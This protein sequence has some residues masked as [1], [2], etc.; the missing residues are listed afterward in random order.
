MF[1]VQD[2]LRMVRVIAADH[3][4]TT[5]EP[6]GWIQAS[7]TS[8]SNPKG[9][10]DHMPNAQCVGWY[11]VLRRP[12]VSDGSRTK[13]ELSSLYVQLFS[14]IFYWV[15]WSKFGFH[16][17]IL[18]TDIHTNGWPNAGVSTHFKQIWYATARFDLNKHPFG[19]SVSGVL[20]LCREKPWAVFACAF[21]APREWPRW[22]SQRKAGHAYTTSM[23]ST[24]AK[25]PLYR[26]K[27]RIDKEPIHS[28]HLCLV[29]FGDHS[30]ESLKPQ[31]QL[32]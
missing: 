9:T 11:A 25:S 22:M 16:H 5:L 17:A 32:T 31:F 2:S 19:F 29:S 13:L 30:N 12:P 7:A 14:I 26:D 18:E 1:G 8:A 24:S 10:K 23:T 28:L 4:W 6:S 20:S 21:E 3:G 15:S 27:I